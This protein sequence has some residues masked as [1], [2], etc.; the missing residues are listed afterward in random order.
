MRMANT[1]TAIIYWLG[2]FRT[3]DMGKKMKIGLKHRGT[4]R[5]QK[6]FR[7]IPL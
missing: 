7:H 3:Q 1:E 5:Q 4:S 2:E 6:K